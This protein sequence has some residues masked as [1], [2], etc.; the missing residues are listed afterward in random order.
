M[1]EAFHSDLETI[2]GNLIEMCTQ[3]ETAVRDAT[4]A[5]LD[6]DLAIAERVIA[7]DVHLDE[8]QVDIDEMAV[9]LLAR[10]SP[11]ATDLRVL[12]SA[13]RMSSS[14]ERAGDL[15]EHVALI[16]RRRH[17]DPV[18]PEVDRADFERM[19]ELTV[20]AIHDAAAVIAER[21]LELAAQVEKRD[22]EIDDLMQSVYG[23]LASQGE[24]YSAAQITDLT[25]LGRFYE[26]MGDHAVSLVRRVGFLVT[27]STLDPR[28]VATDVEVI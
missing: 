1:R 8:L 14:L 3:V 23:R 13:L 5:L 11:V 17:P 19:G 15:A 16:V 21:D 25:L 12:V 10:Q 18:L 7:A 6:G 28:S 4:T 20:A 2:R 9:D 26:R 24:S 22:A 27:G